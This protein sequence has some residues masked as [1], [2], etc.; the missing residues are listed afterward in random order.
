MS[1]HAHFANG[2]HIFRDTRQLDGR[3]G[4]IAYT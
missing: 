4:H 3:L 2:Y 1:T